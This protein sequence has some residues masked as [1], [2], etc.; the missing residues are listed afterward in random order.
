MKQ[1]KLSKEERTLTGA[2]I[3]AIDRMTE[4]AREV[5]GHCGHGYALPEYPVHL[6]ART[7]QEL[8][9]VDPL[10]RTDEWWRNLR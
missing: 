3:E 4:N 5:C 9:T 7:M 1:Q 8:E 10:Y 6:P 2:Q